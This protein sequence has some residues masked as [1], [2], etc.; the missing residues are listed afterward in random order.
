VRDY[1]DVMECNAGSMERS[2]E[3]GERPGRGDDKSILPRN[4]FGRWGRVCMASVGAV[5]YDTPQ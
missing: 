2:R 4:L 1:L 3:P 5:V